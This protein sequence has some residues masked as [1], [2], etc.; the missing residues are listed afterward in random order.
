[1]VVA[2]YPVDATLAR[3][4]APYAR[5]TVEA[6]GL[7]V[8]PPP[9]VVEPA[10]G[11]VLESSSSLLA[12]SVVCAAGTAIDLSPRLA[13]EALLAAFIRARQIG[14]TLETLEAALRLD[15]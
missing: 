10:P 7:V 3:L 14:F 6:L 5:T 11:T 4:L 13:R 15:R 12:D 9:P 1:L 8:A 2:L